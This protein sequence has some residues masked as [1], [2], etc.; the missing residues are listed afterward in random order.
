MNAITIDDNRYKSAEIYAKLHNISIKDV[1]ARSLDLLFRQTSKTELVT[2]DTD[3][4][5]AMA[6]MDSITMKGGKPIP[7]E[8]NG[9]D[10]L[11]DKKY[12]L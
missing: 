7:P 11:I 4:E 12:V 9:L 10:A 3:L 2:N 8:E 5:N 1:V 6:I